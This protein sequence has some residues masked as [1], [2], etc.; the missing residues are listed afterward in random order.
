M[1]KRQY[2]SYKRMASDLNDKIALYERDL[3]GI[4]K[5]NIKLIEDNK[6]REVEYNTLKSE[7]Q[8]LADKLEKTMK[9]REQ[10][11]VAQK[12][13]DPI[14][15]ISIYKIDNNKIVENNTKTISKDLYLFIIKT[16]I[17]NGQK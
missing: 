4:Q 12:Y 9:I 1:P 10:L 16:I 14:Y 11:N 5:H 2:V 15:N 8:I 3:E 17:E 6:H 7:Y 13:N